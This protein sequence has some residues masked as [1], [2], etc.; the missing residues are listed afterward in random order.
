MPSP[1]TTLILFILTLLGA[2]YLLFFE[3][4]FES[5]DTRAMYEKRIVRF[6]AG[7]VERLRL[8]RDHWTVAAVERVDYRTFR[9][10]EPSPGALDGNQVMQLITLLSDSDAIAVLAGDADRPGKMTEYGL[11]APRLEWALQ[12]SSGDEIRLAFGLVTATGD[13]VYLHVRGSPDVVVA[14]LLLFE[15]ADGLLDALIVDTMSDE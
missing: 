6:E 11:A 15:A 3:V 8:R 14:P 12:R 2:A 4:R 13:G 5:T 1:R 10:T 7:S 9:R